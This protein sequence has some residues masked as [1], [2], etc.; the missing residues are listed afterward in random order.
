MIRRT[1]LL[2]MA[3]VACFSLLIL[4]GCN[5]DSEAS[6]ATEHIER[7]ST[8]ADQGQ[9]RSAMLEVRNAIQKEPENVDHSLK[10]ADLYLTVGAAQLA[11]D[12]LEQWM[13]E[14]ADTVGLTL[15]KAYVRQGK[16]V[17]AT[18][19]VDQMNAGNSA[20]STDIQWIQ[21]EISRLRGDLDDAT[22]QYQA[23]QQASANRSDVA[24]GLGRTLLQAEQPDRALDVLD[25]WRAEYGDDPEVLFYKG[26][27]HYRM[28]QLE[29]AASSLTDGLAAIPS[30]D[31]FLPIRRQTLAILTRTLTEQG[32]F[33]QASVYNDILVENTD[34]EAQESTE[35]AIGAIG[36]GDLDTARGI[37]EDLT[38]QNPDNELVNLLLGAVNLQQGN[39]AEGE[40][41]LTQNIDTETSPATFIRLAALAQVDRG[42]RDEALATLERSLLARPS[43]SQ[44]LAV[45]GLLALS[46]PSRANEGITSLNKSLDIDNSQVRLRLALA[47]YY[48]QN[49][50]PEQALGHLRTAFGLQPADWP[51]TE[52]YIGSLLNSGERTEAEAVR[53]QLAEAHADEERAVAIIAV[54]D[55]QLGQSERAKDRLRSF[56][57]DQPDSAVVLRALARIQQETGETAEATESLRRLAVS[58]PD[59]ITVL[60][61]AGQSYLRNHSPDELVDWLM[62]LASQSPSMEANARAL[63][64]QV[65]LQQ[66]QLSAANNLITPVAD[67]EN[68]SVNQVRASLLAREGEQAAALEDWVQARSKITE[69]I[70]LEPENLVYQLIMVRLSIAE[71]RLEEAKEQLNRLESQFGNTARYKVANAQYIAASESTGQ[72][73]DYLYS[74]WQNDD[75]G[76]LAP[77][78]LRFAR[79]EAPDQ[80]LEITRQWAQREPGSVEAWQTQGDWLSQQEQ[81]PE[82]VRAYQEA[83]N[84]NENSLV[85]LNNLAWALKESDPDAAVDYA[86]RAAE[87]APDN[88][89]ILDTYGWTLHMAGRNQEALEVLERAAS[90]APENPEISSH[91]AAVRNL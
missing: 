72:A 60:Q 25:S 49:E 18:E 24:V 12:I 70:T 16:H 9:Y 66:G 87:Q 50:Q 77:S 35:S 2:A 71:G 56:L 76:D 65:R 67:S 41:L 82:A 15:A 62:E 23:L 4:S 58:R 8:Y 34:N 6:A 54:V 47:Q 88:A 3:S 13:P 73:F 27:I 59:D 32:N 89:A 43:D 78:L 29:D 30:S 26:L 10:L 20:E 61:S 7:S 68:S 11:S 79:S 17:S 31:I 48:N 21:A 22:E 38:Q 83:L 51:T 85:T 75:S 55:Y 36:S 64:A 57:E 40:A 52:Y 37:L 46:I 90:L 19:V 84:R 42:R 14:Q 44:L 80:F 69:A 63:A 81:W 5:L 45:H 86:A 91:L 39:I 53:N 1:S 74:E 28:N 33:T